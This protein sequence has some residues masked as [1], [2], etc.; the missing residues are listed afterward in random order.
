MCNVAIDYDGVITA[1]YAHY[2]QLAKDFEKS[3]H[4]VYVISAANKQRRKRVVDDLAMM[5]FPC[6]Q[7]IVRPDNFISTHEN[8]GSFKKLWLLKLNIDL[9]FD[10]EV[11]IY[12]QAGVDF[13][14][15]K[16]A[17]VRI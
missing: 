13:S 4:N 2:L 11:K 1:N 15:I 9:W 8:I 12:E 10:N 6:K 16:T 7:L 17:I 3:G 14:D 5:G